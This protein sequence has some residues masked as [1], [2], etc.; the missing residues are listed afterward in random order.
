MDR[1]AARVYA[2]MGRR[3]H[4]LRA[5]R[6]RRRALRSGMTPAERRLW[7]QIRRRQL[8]GWRWRRQYSVGAYVLDFFCPA[9]R[10]AVE[11]DGVVHEDPARAAYDSERE[12]WLWEAEGIRVIRFENR[13]VMERVE[14]VVEAIRLSLPAPHPTSLPWGEESSG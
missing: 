3:L 4:N 2:R 12:R 13:E 9:A 5:L 8:D 11:L 10:L 7:K 1:S 6:S 14:V